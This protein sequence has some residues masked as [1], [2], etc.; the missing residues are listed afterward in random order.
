M[1]LKFKKWEWVSGFTNSF[2]ICRQTQEIKSVERIITYQG[3]WG[4][5]SQPIRERIRIPTLDIRT[6]YLVIMLSKNGRKKNYYIHR[7]MLETFV[8]PCPEGM[9]ACHKN[10]IKT[11]NRLENLY[12]GTH[13]DNSKDAWKNG[14]FTNRV[15]PKG[16]NHYSAKLRERDVIEIRTKFFTG[17]FTQTEL[18]QKFG[19]SKENIR[20]IILG[21]IWRGIQAK[22]CLTEKRVVQI[23]K[24]W[25]HKQYLYKNER[26]PNFVIKHLMRRYKIN[27]LTLEQIVQ[28]KIW[29]DVHLKPEFLI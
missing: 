11:D 23:R 25:A 15:L 24:I 5:V 1:V 16:E 18:A 2:Q 9:E 17:N 20:N 12:W 29:V 8:G 7:L 26:I 22:G 19:V 6:G 21:K 27:Q 3:R 4:I 13:S 28:N 10:D 14:S